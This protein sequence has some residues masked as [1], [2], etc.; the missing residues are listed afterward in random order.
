MSANKLR[1]DYAKKL[2]HIWF[3]HSLVSEESETPSDET[4][5]GINDEN[6]KEIKT[7][8]VNSLNKLDP[9]NLPFANKKSEEALKRY[10]TSQ[11]ST[12]KKIYQEIIKLSKDESIMEAT[13][14]FYEDGWQ[15]DVAKD[16][17]IQSS[18]SLKK[19]SESKGKELLF[20]FW[21]EYNIYRRDVCPRNTRKKYI[22]KHEWEE[23]Q[24]ETFL[25][26]YIKKR[27]D[28]S[29]C[30]LSPYTTEFSYNI[31]IDKLIE[32]FYAELLK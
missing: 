32:F 24:H 26:Y 28:P 21:R 11:K 29:K 1:S 15:F 20:F 18:D 31:P 9:E 22:P 17:Y 8:F 12:S 2:K 14:E 16:D 25:E 3:P 5:L 10:Q 7:V 23:P 4:N 19:A 6:W 27:T 30:Y 13:C